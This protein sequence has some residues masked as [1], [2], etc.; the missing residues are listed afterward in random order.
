M[1]S[2]ALRA[3]LVPKA[4]DCSLRA[5]LTEHLPSGPLL[6]HDQDS[7]HRINLA[8]LVPPQFTVR[9]GHFRQATMVAFD[10]PAL[11]EHIQAIVITQLL[12]VA[13]DSVR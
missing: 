9:F 7:L 6:V 3:H 11:L 8:D 12:G 10:N 1:A 4:R 13:A 5:G 2:H